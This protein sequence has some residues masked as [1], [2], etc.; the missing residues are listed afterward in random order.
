MHQFFERSRAANSAVSYGI[1]Q[2]FD[3][4]HAFMVVLVTSKNEEDPTK[5]EGNRVVTRV[6]HYKSEG[7]FPDAQ[8]QLTQQ[9]V[10][11]PVRILKSKILWLSSSPARIITL[12]HLSVV[13]KTRVLIQSGP[14]PFA[15]YPPPQ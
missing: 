8:G 13:M 3:L 1:W 11:K 6:S 9:S 10:F 12:W 14:K 15:A 2:K 7:I 4:I 5:N